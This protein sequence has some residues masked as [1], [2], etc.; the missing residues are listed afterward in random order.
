MNG[1]L[2][3]NAFHE[4][5]FVREIHGFMQWGKLVV[6]IFL[7]LR[8]PKWSE[9]YY[10]KACKYHKYYWI[11]YNLTSILWGLTLTGGSTCGVWETIGA[12][13]VLQED[14]SRSGRHEQYEMCLWNIQW[15]IAKCILWDK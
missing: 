11:Y 6:D 14:R 1:A 13:T 3:D 2:I 12:R 4:S 10:T 8:T 9:G 7:T 5:I 15:Y